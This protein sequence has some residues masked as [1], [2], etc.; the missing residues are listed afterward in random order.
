MVFGRVLLLGDAAF[1]A[2]PHVAMGVTKA[3]LD[4]YRLARVLDGNTDIEQGL[5]AYSDTQSRFGHAAVAWARYLGRH[6]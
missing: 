4:A 5:A 6:L 3:A 1:V 2:R